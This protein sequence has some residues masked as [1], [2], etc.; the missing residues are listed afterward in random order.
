MKMRKAVVGVVAM[1]GLGL[2]CSTSAAQ[3]TQEKKAWDEIEAKSKATAEAIKG[4][5]GVAVT[6]MPDRKTWNT[7]ELASNPAKW[8]IEEG[9]SVFRS[10]CSDKDYK[11]AVAKSVKNVS[12]VNDPSLKKESKDNYGNKFSLK[13][14][15]VE[16]RY[17]KDSA[18]LNEKFTEFLKKA[19]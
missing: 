3:T 19:L 9:E 4:F 17:H 5:C 8:C 2:L 13:N 10:L 11:A 12:C 14:G 6:I 1:M 7:V 16:W 18:N 15:T